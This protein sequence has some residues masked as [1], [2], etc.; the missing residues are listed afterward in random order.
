MNS[1][2]KDENPI[3]SLI[4]FGSNL[5]RRHEFLAAAMDALLGIDGLLSIVA[6]EPMITKAIVGNDGP[7]DQPNFVNAV[8]RVTTELS[9]S[10][11]HR[12]LLDI[13]SQLGRERRERWGARQV[14]LDLLLHG[15]E[16][17]DQPQLI[18][19]HPR[20]TFRRFVLEPAIEIASDMIHPLSGQTI[21]QL[22][23]RINDTASK[24]TIAVTAESMESWQ[25]LA[26]KMDP[27]DA[28][29]LQ[30]IESVAPAK[31]RLLIFDLEDF[32]DSA[33]LHKSLL[34][35][36]GPTLNLTGQSEQEKLKELSAAISSITAV[37]P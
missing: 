18:V 20:M 30:N 14:D 16:L 9:A 31:S 1:N 37:D 27:A 34:H 25:S 21:K 24:I 11:L 26:K 12:S 17:I 19:P 13:E 35:F 3:E 32:E 8:F 23:D 33:T 22:L 15:G 36:R 29:E 10:E 5:G 7:E 28:I 4:A 6:S 2:S